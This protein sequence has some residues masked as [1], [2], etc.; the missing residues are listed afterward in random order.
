ML[1][2]VLLL[3]WELQ[4]AESR[5]RQLWNPR[6]RTEANP[7]AISCTAYNHIFDNGKTPTPAP[8]PP[9]ST[10]SPMHWTTLSVSP[11]NEGCCTQKGWATGCV[12]TISKALGVA[13]SYTILKLEAGT[14]CNDNYT[15]APSSVSDYQNQVVGTISK[16]SYLTIEA[17]DPTNV[18]EAHAASSQAAPGPV[19]KGTYTVLLRRGVRVLQRTR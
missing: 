15:G 1:W 17:A 9:P 3:R 18:P 10:P 6:T 13:R 8:P 4:A 12:N 19:P 2:Y 14:Y 11:P 16:M 7:S 5:R